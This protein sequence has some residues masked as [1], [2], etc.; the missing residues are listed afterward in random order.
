MK[1]LKED[2]EKAI[3]LN[4]NGK[5]FSEIAIILN[6]ETRGVQVKL[7]KLGFGE[8]KTN[9]N[10]TLTCCNCNKE[11]SGLKK[12]KRKF[13]SKSCA[14]QFNNSKYPKRKRGERLSNC[15]CCG[16]PLN[17]HQIKFCSKF[18]S[19]EYHWNE[20]VMKIENGD[21]SFGSDT[22][23]KYLI[24][25]FG[26]NCMKCGWHEINPTTGL[27]PIQMEHKD[28][29][30]TNHNLNNLELLC[31]NCHSLTPTY[32]ALNKGNGRTKRREK[33]KSLAY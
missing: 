16:N 7:N 14:I 18:C 2:V 13:C 4:R 24:E 31:P 8:N 10:E 12:N 17:L 9:P 1:W 6:R 21:T 20:R 30:S 3:E 26:N 25:K 33:R 15:L 22:Y 11:F 27:V 19:I 23:K 32:G 5:R 28:G 29:N